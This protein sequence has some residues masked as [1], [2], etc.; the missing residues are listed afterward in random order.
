MKLEISSKSLVFITV[1]V[2]GFGLLIYGLNEFDRH[3]SKAEFS[4]NIESLLKSSSLEAMGALL[5]D[6]SS[7]E[8]LLSADL[9]HLYR[10]ALSVTE[11]S[12]RVNS[13]SLGFLLSRNGS[14]SR[15]HLFGS[16]EQGILKNIRP[17][18]EITTIIESF[19]NKEASII[20]ANFANFE[21]RKMS[22][23]VLP[24]AIEAN[25]NGYLIVFYQDNY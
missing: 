5:R 10:L 12:N 19:E 25:R 14:Y 15:I 16:D 9:D 13:Y 7:E 22:Q 23:I 4:E 3:Q 2:A 6:R 20:D 17:D 18:P 21:Q 1:V 24:I 8:T 11:E